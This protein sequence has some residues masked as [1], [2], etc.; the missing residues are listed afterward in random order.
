MEMTSVESSLWE[1]VWQPGVPF[2]QEFAGSIAVP[3]WHPVRKG[4]SPQPLGARKWQSPGPW[5]L[6][7]RLRPGGSETGV[8]RSAGAPRK[9][10]RDGVRGRCLRVA[11]R[12]ATITTDVGTSSEWKR[13]TPP[14][15]GGNPGHQGTPTLCNF[16]LGTLFANVCSPSTGRVGVGRL[17][18]AAP[19]T[20]R[21]LGPWRLSNES[22]KSLWWPTG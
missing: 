22:A 17:M 19:A 12:A 21:H 15:K 16:G 13:P 9:A 3:F 20:C 10:Y 1:Q 8:G 5:E 7:T 4:K 14:A 18:W 11:S 2:W 6:V